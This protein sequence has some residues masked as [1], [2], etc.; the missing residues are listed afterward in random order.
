[1]EKTIKKNKGFLSIKKEFKT[2]KF[3]QIDSQTLIVNEQFE[4]LIGNYII[5]NNK[6]IFIITPEI[7]NRDFISLF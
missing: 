1:M 3:E 7:Y 5:I 2:H 6:K 4:C